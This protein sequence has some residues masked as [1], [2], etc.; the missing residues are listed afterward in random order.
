MAKKMNEIYLIENNNAVVV[1][2]SVLH[3]ERGVLIDA[4]DID[5]IKNYRW[6][7]AKNLNGGWYAFTNCEKGKKMY[8]HRFIMDCP[9]D[10]VIDHKNGNTL[11]NRKRNLKICTQRQ[12]NQNKKMSNNNTSGYRNIYWNKINNTWDIQIKHKRIG[13][14][15][16]LE[17]AVKA[18]NKYLVENMAEELC[19]YYDR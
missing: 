9:E 15:K 7:L 6:C 18:R 13:Q 19:L 11:D 8:L 1:T 12:N 3:G 5:K 14:F 17:D 2:E 16:E 10:K 4:E